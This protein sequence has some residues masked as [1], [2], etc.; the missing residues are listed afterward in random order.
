VKDLLLTGRSSSAKSV[1]LDYHSM[2][3][4]DVNTG[5]LSFPSTKKRHEAEEANLFGRAGE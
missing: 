4:V 3:A 5:E 2:W 1:T